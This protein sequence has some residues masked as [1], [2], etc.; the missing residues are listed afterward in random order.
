MD[1]RRIGRLLLELQD[2]IAAA[3]QAADEGVAA[4]ELFGV[5]EREVGRE[6]F[7]QPD[8]VPIAFGDGVAPP[9]VRDLVDDRRV[10]RGDAL[11]AIEDDG[12]VLGA[13][14]EAGGLHVRQLLVGIGAD[15]LAEEVERAAA[16][17]LED[18]LAGLGVLREDPDLLRHAFRRRVVTG[19]EARH[20]DGIEP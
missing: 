5:E 2:A 14:A 19:R 3:A 4:V 16:G 6:A 1:D 17:E 12:G 10:A 9:L 15:L 13:A 11:L 7:A 18:A 8:I 20:A